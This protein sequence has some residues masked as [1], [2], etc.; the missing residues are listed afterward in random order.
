[1][2]GEMTDL[3]SRRLGAG[4]AFSR[5]AGAAPRSESLDGMRGLAALSVLLL[6]YTQIFRDTSYPSF[7]FFD[8]WMSFLS[9]TPLVVLWSG[10]Q[11]VTLFFLLS[12]YALYRMLSNSQISTWHYVMRRIIRLWPPYILSILLSATAIFF[13]GSH[14][15]PGQSSW[16]NETLST[17]L[18]WSTFVRHITL[19]GF[20]NTQTINPAVWS[21]VIEMRLSLLFPLILWLLKKLPSQ[22]VLA[23]SFVLFVLG[24]Y[25]RMK[26]GA[27]TTS[28]YGTLMFQVYFVAGAIIAMQE[29][30]LIS[31]YNQLSRLSRAM[32]ASLAIVLYANLLHLSPTFS[33]MLGAI[34]VMIIA[35]SSNTC[36][37]LLSKPITQWFGKISYSLYLYHFAVLLIFINALNG[38]V[39]L[40]VIA[41]GALIMSV[42]LAILSYRLVEV[43][44]IALSRKIK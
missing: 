9:R 17:H 12:G 43:P 35:L 30:E 19:V 6:H 22:L 32:L 8:H 11:A 7:T 42:G 31:R 15:I 21:L 33:A 3:K 23:V 39:S 16:L 2:L 25:L 28:V 29:A 14:P 36:K 4:T 26:T 10:G 1:M 24:T 20:F 38:L 41:I 34:L 37:C 27:T 40:P 13:I 5:T 18:T 44:A